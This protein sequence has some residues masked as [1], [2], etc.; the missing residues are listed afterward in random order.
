MGGTITSSRPVGEAIR[1]MSA[2][3]R[4]RKLQRE[5]CLEEQ[6]WPL[7][8]RTHPAS[9][10]GL[11]SQSPAKGSILGLLLSVLGPIQLRGRVPGAHGVHAGQHWGRE[12]GEGCEGGIGPGEVNRR[13]ATQVKDVSTCHVIL[14][15][16]VLTPLLPVGIR[17][18]ILCQPNSSGIPRDYFKA[19]LL[20]FQ[21]LPTKAN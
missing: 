4:G 2:E 13:C 6:R 21:K 7:D 9:K 5:S 15:P 14:S 10:T 18:S 1:E 12:Q 8:Q 3:P 20:P 11:A 17:S 16:C 19:A